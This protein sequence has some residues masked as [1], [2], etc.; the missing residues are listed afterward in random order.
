V[1]RGRLGLLLFAVVAVVVVALGLTRSTGDG[2]DSEDSNPPEVS[3]LS[4]GAPILEPSSE[5]IQVEPGTGCMA[6]TNDPTPSCDQFQADGIDV[7]WLVEQE[8]ENLPVASFLRRESSTSWKRVLTGGGE[9]DDAPFELVNV[10][11]DDLTNDGI[12]EAIY[13]FHAGNDLGVDVVESSGTVILHLDLPRG[14]I[15]VGGGQLI[16]YVPDGDRWTREEIG[17]DDTGTLEV[18]VTETV[19]GP[20]QGNL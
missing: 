18:R 12:P 16:T 5:V 13:G 1:T 10:R 15:L 9:N 8:G 19:D 6:T 20:P 2:G 3:E 4:T 7:A 14:Q 17:P 11:T